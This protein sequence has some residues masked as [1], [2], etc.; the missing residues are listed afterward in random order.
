[1]SPTRRY[2]FERLSSFDAV[3]LLTESQ[4]IDVD[5][6]FNNPRNTC[7]IPNSRSLPSVARPEHGH[8]P[9]L[10]VILGSLT[11]RKRLDHAVSALGLA[12]DAGGAELNLRIYGQGPEKA[13]LRKLIAARDLGQSVVLAGYSSSAWQEFARASFTMLT[14][15]LEG[16]GLVLI[17]AMSVGCIPIAYDVPYGPADIIDDGVNGFL[18]KAGDVPALAELILKLRTMEPSAVEDMRLQAV[19]KASTFNDAAVVDRW[20]AE[21]RAAVDRKLRLLLKGQKP[22]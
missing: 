3:V 14:S 8:D 15:K 18:V 19:A 6:V 16:Q 22:Q 10:G 9:Q 1:L 7:V 5:L 13:S 21:M 2:V 12:R 17:E 20:G 11:N 4:K